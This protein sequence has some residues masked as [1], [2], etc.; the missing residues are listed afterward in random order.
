MIDYTE[1]K[2]STGKDTEYGSPDKI[3]FS[4]GRQTGLGT[5]S[6]ANV[7]TLGSVQIDN[8][9]LTAER[10]ILPPGERQYPYRMTL[11]N[12]QVTDIPN[13]VYSGPASPAEKNDFKADAER[14]A[15]ACATAIGP[16]G[17]T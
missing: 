14:Y 1:L 8:G 6:V 11:N 15:K 16:K 13:D 9:D 5:P 17:P 7:I 4:G 12:G 10:T 3:Y 2:C